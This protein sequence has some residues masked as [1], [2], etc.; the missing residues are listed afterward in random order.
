MTSVLGTLEVA[1][2]LDELSRIYTFLDDLAARH[3]LDD[4][5]RR[6]LSLIVEELFSNTVSYGYP[7]AVADT[8]KTELTKDGDRL[9][10]TLEDHATAFDTG[11]APVLDMTE[12]SADDMSV[13]G[14]GL[15]LVHQVS[16]EVSHSRNDGTNTTRVVLRL[17]SNGTDQN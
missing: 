2:E 1:N 11:T 16:E 5:T 17:S 10:L 15:F 7:D 9:V 4:H 12:T 13:G 6:H 14:L 3:G 8:I